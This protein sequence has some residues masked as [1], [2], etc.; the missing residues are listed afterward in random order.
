MEV[1]NK[2]TEPLQN[3]NVIN[4][5]LFN[6]IAMIIII[7]LIAACFILISGNNQQVN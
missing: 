6:P 5:F 4:N 3:Y 2:P 7:L 1:V